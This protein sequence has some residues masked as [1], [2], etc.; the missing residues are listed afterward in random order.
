MAR[1]R[2][3]LY[4]PAP[5]SMDTCHQRQ[6]SHSIRHIGLV[7]LI[8]SC[9]NCLPSLHPTRCLGSPPSP[10]PPPQNLGPGYQCFRPATPN[11]ISFDASPPMALS[12]APLGV[13]NSGCVH[14]VHAPRLAMPS[15]RRVP[16]TRRRGTARWPGSLGPPRCVLGLWYRRGCSGGRPSSMSSRG[17]MCRSASRSR[18]LLKAS[19]QETPHPSPFPCSCARGII[20]LILLCTPPTLAEPG[21]PLSTHH[22]KITQPSQHTP[23]PQTISSSGR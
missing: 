19:Y 18:Y 5:R 10:E 7:I 8:Q 20:T 17:G 11:V 4:G 3:Q 16:P 22:P 13:T 12:S 15:Q 21:C 9:P 2:Q 6:H 14:V 23:S 1:H